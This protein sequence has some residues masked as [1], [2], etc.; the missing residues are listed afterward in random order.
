MP[1]APGE[2]LGPYQLLAILGTGGMGEVYRARDSKLDRDV[3]I[4]LLPLDVASDSDRLARFEREARTLAAL[5]HPNIVTIHSIEEIDG[6]RFLTM[7]V[8]N[9]EPLDRHRIRGGLPLDQILAIAIPVAD[10]VAAAHERGIVH[11]DLKPANIIVGVGGRI[12]VLDFGLAKLNRAGEPHGLTVPTLS[13]TGDG[14]IVGTAAYMSPEQAQG[15]AVDYRS[16]VFSFGVILYEL[17][18]G[19]RPFTGDNSLEVLSAI[20]RDVPQAV[21][22]VKPLL[23]REFDRIVR[24]CLAKDPEERYQAAKDLRNDL[25]DLRGDLESGELFASPTGAAHSFSRQSQLLSWLMTIGGAAALALGVGTFVASRTG[26]ALPAAPQPVTATFTQLTAAPGLEMQP[27]LSPDGKWMAYVAGP[28]GNLDIY[29]Q[30]VGGRTA[31]N[32]TKDS[33]ADDSQPRFSPDGEHTAFRSERQGGGIFVMGRTGESVR[34][35]TDIGYNPAWSPDGR[36]IVFAT[37]WID[38]NPY[39]RGGGSQLWQVDVQTGERRMLYKGDAVQPD[40]S[41]HGKRIAFWATFLPGRNNAW[42]DIWTIPA[43]GGAPVSVTNDAAVDWNP[44]WSPDGGYLYF[45]SDRGGS[46]NVW[47]IA[48]DEETGRV[49]GRPEPLTT[50]A[51][52]AGHLSLSADGTRLAFT[53]IDETRNLE[54]IRFNAARE[55]VEGE[56][57]AVTTGSTGWGA[58][59]VSPD[60]DWLAFISLPSPRYDVFV[61]RTDGSGLLQLTNDGVNLIPRWSPDGTHISFQSSQSGVSQVWMVKPDGS[62]LRQVTSFENPTL[63]PIWSPDGSRIM[64]TRVIQQGGLGSTPVIFNVHKPVSDQKL[65]ELPPA[66][67][68]SFFT[69]RDWSPDGNQVLGYFSTATSVAMGMYSLRSR[70]YQQIKRESVPFSYVQWLRDSRRVLY[71]LKGSN[72]V[73]LI[74]TQTKREHEVLSFPATEIIA[75]TTSP[76]EGTMYFVR[77]RVE[78]DIWLATVPKAGPI[79]PSQ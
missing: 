64:A 39:T 76:D 66:P 47:R 75:F 49:R 20:V 23:P 2:R 48:V 69:P 41:P 74:D 67:N 71:T 8:V 32:L 51:R 4:K 17:A 11:R 36:R 35:L 60:G 14:H 44:I 30:G 61:S 34:R 5:T 70:T 37:E 72:R 40:W 21:T 78:G 68:G 46:M 77:D 1:L 12:K 43:E 52:F 15:R 57:R 38:R 53:S 33:A 16:D 65:E 7:E 55:R 50:P 29:L 63:G 13:L 59:A 24:R 22:A 42:R 31:I 56:P 3:A 79:G 73:V 26:Q 25:R 28:P 27:N 18:T 9:G 58:P 62:E 10:A 54:A 45:A 19:H 6:R